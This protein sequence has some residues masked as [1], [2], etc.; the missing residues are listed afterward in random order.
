MNSTIFQTG[1]TWSN[2]MESIQKNREKFE[3]VYNE[4][5]LQDSDLVPFRAAAPLHI[6]A[7]GEEWCPDVYNT[8]GVIAKVADSAT[9][10]EFRIFERDSHPELMDQFLTDGTKRSIPVFA[11]Y[12][13]KFDLLGWWGG[14]NKAAN[15]WVNG[16]RKGRPYDQIPDDEMKRF[17]EEFQSNYDARFREGNF[18]EIKE[19]LS[20]ALEKNNIPVNASDQLENS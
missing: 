17:R 15:E 10:C 16:F 4:F 3:R 18:E 8:F 13:A 19:V 20:S 5:H 12:D 14:R 1:K 7:I 11:F 2:Y 9:S 6:L